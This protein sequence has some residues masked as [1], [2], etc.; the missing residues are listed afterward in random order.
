MSCKVVSFVCCFWESTEGEQW[1]VHGE[2]VARCVE[3]FVVF[4]CV[5]E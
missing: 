5:S 1:V 4:V 2:E 3:V